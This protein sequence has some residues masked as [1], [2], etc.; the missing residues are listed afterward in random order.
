MSDGTVKGYQTKDYIAKRKKL[1]GLFFESALP[2]E[3]LVEL[4]RKRVKPALGGRR[5]RLFRKF[6][7]VPA[8]VQTLYFHTD[9]ANLHYQGIGIEGYASWRIDPANPEVALA[10]MDFFDEDD[11]MARTNDELRTICVEAVRHVVANMTIEDALRKKDEIG[12]NLMGQLKEVEKKWGIVFDHVGIEQVRVMS[13][14]I[15]ENL[16]ADFRNGL[17]L[18]VEKKRIETDRQI[19][20]EQNAQREKSEGERLS[21][22]KKLGLAQIDNKARLAD[23]DLDEKHKIERKQRE[24]REDEYRREAEFRAEKD[25]REHA[26]ATQEKTLELELRAVEAK[27][28]GALAE[29]EKLKAGIELTGVEVTRAKRNAE[30]QYTPEALQAELIELL[31]E[32]LGA[33]KIGEYTVFAGEASA[34]PVG[35]ALAEIMPLLARFGIDFRAMAKSGGPA[36]PGE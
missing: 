17:R 23:A 26:L 13:K 18:E 29:I 28:L 35:R 36:A 15:F 7:R 6:L 32:I 2:N 11:P 31:P 27:L 25:K 4:G 30:Q 21:T 8:Y 5:F 16:Q 9:N 34:S 1:N 19:A 10:A 14:T 3:Y 24:L 33:L 20:S 12:D 22:D